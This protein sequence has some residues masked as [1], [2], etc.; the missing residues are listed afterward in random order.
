MLEQRLMERLRCG[1]TESK[2]KL[3]LVENELN[4]YIQN[5]RQLLQEAMAAKD[6]ANITRVELCSITDK[7]CAVQELPIHLVASDGSNADTLIR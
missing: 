2:Q 6:P 4:S 5:V 7:L 3:N 1:R